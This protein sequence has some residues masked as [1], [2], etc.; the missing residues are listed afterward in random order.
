MS[1]NNRKIRRHMSKKI[2]SMLVSIVLLYVAGCSKHEGKLGLNVNP[3]PI[4]SVIE[5]KEEA[6]EVEKP[7]VPVDQPVKTEEV[8]QKS[9]TQAE[10]QQKKVLPQPTRL[11]RPT[12]R[13]EGENLT[14]LKVYENSLFNLYASADDYQELITK[15]QGWGRLDRVEFYKKELEKVQRDIREVE[16]EILELQAQ[17]AQQAS[18]AQPE[19]ITPKP[20]PEVRPI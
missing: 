11:P 2:L 13:H 17:E 19:A 15:N 8:Q 4:N 5:K 10:R 20:E 7:K 14:L 9:Q 12:Q 1:K 6:R 3:E 16:D 18:A